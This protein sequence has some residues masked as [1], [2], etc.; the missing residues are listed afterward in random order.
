MLSGGGA[1]GAYEV[2]TLKVLEALGV[3]PSLVAGVSIG[4]INAAVWVAHGRR[5]AALEAAWHRMRAA[6]IGLRWVTLALRWL[7]AA[8]FVI[9]VIETLIT[10]A[11]SRELSGSYWLWGKSSGRI[12]VASTL[13]DATAWMIAGAIGIVTL[14][15]SRPLEDWLARAG[16]PA[17]PLRMHRRAGYVLLA[18]FVVHAV[19]WVFGWPWPHRFSASVVLVT[20][21]FW[22]A[23]WPGRGGRWLR[24]MLFAMM[25]ETG[26]RG[27]WGSR[28]RRRVIED[29]VRRGLPERLVSGETRLVVS[30]LAID[31]GR[32]CHFVN[33]SDPSGTFEQRVN[34]ELGEVVPLRTPEDMITATVASSAIPGV[35]EPV[36]VGGRNFV[37]A[38][39]FSNQPLHIA[40]ADDADAVLTVL[41]SP[42]DRPSLTPHRESL[43][44]LGGR[45]LEL[46]NWRDL[47]T[48]LRHLPEG[49]NRTGNPARVCVVE[50]RLPLPGGVLT[51]DPDMAAELIALGERDTWHALDRAGWLEPIEGDPRPA[52]PGSPGSLEPHDGDR[53]R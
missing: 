32:V 37:D 40:I 38:G 9:A 7:G 34:R 23:N 1:L 4:A 33:W 15:L 10:L 47:Q 18:L 14:V 31:S 41:L 24:T 45:L 13:L 19:V 16:P 22:L 20:L 3:V 28:A 5:S 11:G 49:W 48:E 46:A 12:D 2:G 53:V 35:F 6:T 42:S 17:D 30:A 50:P 51:F 39:G 25:P 44:T 29:L 52:D 26:G 43:L 21:L 27:L 36:R 8:L